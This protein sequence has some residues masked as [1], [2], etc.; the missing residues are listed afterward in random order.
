[1]NLVTFD[2]SALIVECYLSSYPLHVLGHGLTIVFTVLHVT[3]CPSAWHMHLTMTIYD[4]VSTNEGVNLTH[5]IHTL[6]HSP[7]AHT[8]ILPVKDL[9]THRM[10]YS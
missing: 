1:M 10:L 7:S 6:I 8:C 3:I 5:Q 9:T 4:I 2:N